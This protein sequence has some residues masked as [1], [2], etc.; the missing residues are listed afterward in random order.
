MKRFI[1]V[2]FISSLIVVTGC[3]GLPGK[4]A[5]PPVP[6]RVISLEQVKEALRQRREAFQDLKA[7]ARLTL[8][9]PDR[10]VTVRQIILLHKGPYLRMETLDFF[11]QPSAYFTSNSE[12]IKIY[13]PG[14]GKY[15][16]GSA[17]S[18]RFS[19][20]L[21]VDVNVADLVL[22]LTGNLPDAG[23][24]SS[25][26]LSYRPQDGTY[27]L[28]QTGIEGPF[29]KRLVWV[30]PEGLNPLMVEFYH[31]GSQAVLTVEYGKHR[32][33]GGYILPTRVVI[34]RPRHN[35]QI[36]LRY[37]SAQV[38]EGIS[39]TSFLLPVPEGVEVIDLDEK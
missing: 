23:G 21:G 12:G 8:H 16:V 24:R 4:A 35:V 33:V 36:K 14:E 2:F 22:L 10:N 30:E 39:K 29:S 38:N 31:S 37:L 9:T 26:K 18:R 34:T 25:E 28:S 6:A 20:F 11:G 5:Q 19:D 27:V 17:S 32:D 7:S 1:A 3:T 13:Y 15:F